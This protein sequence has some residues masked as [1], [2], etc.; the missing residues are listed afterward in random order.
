MCASFLL[1]KEACVTMFVCPCMCAKLTHYIQLSHTV[2]DAAAVA[3]HA[4]VSASVI[5]GDI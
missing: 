5:C 2:F 1:I 3:G 4:C